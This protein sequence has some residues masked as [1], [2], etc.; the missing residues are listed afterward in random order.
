MFLTDSF[1]IP[2]AEVGNIL[3]KAFTT[4]VSYSRVVSLYLHNYHAV[5]N[6]ILV[7][8]DFEFLLHF[9]ECLPVHC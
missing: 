3:S 9:L 2:K 1:M 6:I 4:G 7:E 8:F 5:Y